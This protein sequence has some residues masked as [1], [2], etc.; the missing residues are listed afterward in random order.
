M[1]VDGIFT[2]GGPITG[3]RG[4][5]IIEFFF[6]TPIAVL[7]DERAGFREFGSVAEETGAVQVDVGEVKRHRAA[8]GDLLGVGQVAASFVLLASQ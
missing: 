2:L 1:L 3:P 4:F 8:L 7:F 6:A 5:G